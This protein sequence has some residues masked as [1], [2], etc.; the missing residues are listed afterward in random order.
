MRLLKALAVFVILVAAG[1]L[2]N[3]YQTAIRGK[4]IGVIYLTGTIT[5][6]TAKDVIPLLKEAV[7]REDI[8][9]VVLRINSPG[10]AVAP[11]QEIYNYIM[12]HRSRKKIYASIATVGASGAYYVAS[13]CNRVYADAGS[14]VGSI[15]VIFTISQIRDLLDKLGIKPVVIKSGRFKD[16]GS[17]FRDMT[18][19]E[20]EYIK[21]LLDEIHERFIRDVAAGRGLPYDEVKRLADGRIYTGETAKRLKLVDRVAPMWKVVEDLSKDLGYK[22]VL[23]TVVLE[24]RKG[25]WKRLRGEAVSFIKD[26][27]TEILQEGIQ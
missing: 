27:R 2:L 16:V 20:R 3:R 8:A 15:G 13:A 21:G 23:E 6:E 22:T 24:S 18:P 1:T 9:G 17:P 19:E 4:R 11:S 10:G 26:L 7:E 5:D 25:F 14:I 12:E